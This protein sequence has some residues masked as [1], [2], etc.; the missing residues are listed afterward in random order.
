MRY[1]LEFNDS[2]GLGI[3]SRQVNSRMLQGHIQPI[4]LFTSEEE[5]VQELRKRIRS[6]FSVQK[7]FC[8]EEPIPELVFGPPQA[9][10]ARAIASSNFEFR[11]FVA[12]ASRNGLTPFCL[13]YT[14]DKF[15]SANPDKLSLVKMCFSH[16]R[17]RN[18]GPKTTMRKVAR[19][20]EID[21]KLISDVVTSWGESLVVFH[22]RLL[23]EFTKCVTTEEMSK[24][25]KTL[26]PY[27]AYRLLFDLATFNSIIFENFV[28]TESETRFWHTVII[29]A[30][31][32]ATRIH[33]RK[34][35]MVP[36][37]PH[38]KAANPCWWWYPN[39]FLGLVDEFLENGGDSSGR[40]RSKFTEP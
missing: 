8:L 2:K 40:K 33:G 29:P 36:L 27:G 1:I 35:L 26:G 32:D 24:V 23:R 6:Q 10:M 20:Q 9:I 17:G 3:S 38:E 30:F 37:V 4:D 7:L 34:P 39:E 18:G 31:M 13:E 22:H 16:G 25:F 14:K 15:C 19:I 28:P 12:K 21:G 5:A 11:C